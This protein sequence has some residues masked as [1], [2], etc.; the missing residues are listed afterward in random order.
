MFDWIDKPTLLLDRR[1]MEANIRRMTAKS[2]QQG[3]RL[4]PHFKTHQSRI[5]GEEFR[6]L[7]VQSI[8]IS[9]VEM[10]EYFA[11]AGWKDITIA[12]PVNLRQLPHIEYLA[13]KT[14]LGLL[15]ESEFSARRLAE[16]M[17]APAEIWIEI[18][19][20]A[21]RSG[22]AWDDYE[23]LY[24]IAGV[25]QTA[26]N[27]HLHGLLTHA[28]HTYAAPSPQEICRIFQRSVA[29]INQSRAALTLRFELHLEVSVGD[30]P[31]CVLCDVFG[32]VD[33]IRPGNFVFFDA[34][35]YTWGVCRAEDIAVALAC[36]VVGLHPER[37]EAVLYGG[38]VH[39]SKDFFEENGVRKYGL[40]ALPVEGGWS[41]PLPDTYVAG[42]SQ[43]HGV[44][45][46]PPGTLARLKVGD[47][48]MILPAH[49]C[50]TAQA[51]GSFTTLTGEIIPMLA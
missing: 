11:A 14:R 51:M 43:E 21:R 28:G 41:D 37:N 23:T 30:T 1:K 19:T 31:G 26:P 33:E 8:T 42:L 7:G 34:E 6:N 32:P 20:G 29:T 15:V 12:F 5:I 48:V 39:L 2:S 17:K 49:S 9:S 3:L 27:L 38:A 10:A 36:P 13:T 24:A 35:Q 18:D 22:V 46:V 45:R 16:Q 40:A 50:L 44:L 4:R 25:L 47:L